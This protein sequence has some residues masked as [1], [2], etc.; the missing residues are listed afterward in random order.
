MTKEI[1]LNGAS[2]MSPYKRTNVGN[3]KSK[4]NMKWNIS[5]GE[6]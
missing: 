5:N 1:M 2:P 4:N 3:K 6:N